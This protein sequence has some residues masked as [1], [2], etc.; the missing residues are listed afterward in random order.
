MQCV[1]QELDQ[2]ENAI[3]ASSATSKVKDLKQKVTL[4]VCGKFE[5]WQLIS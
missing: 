3:F 2:L 4:M 1:G 5:T